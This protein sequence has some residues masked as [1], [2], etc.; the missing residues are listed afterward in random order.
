[1]RSTN[2]T[3]ELASSLRSGPDALCGSDG[4]HGVTALVLCQP[5]LCGF[6]LLTQQSVPHLVARTA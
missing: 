4:W 1:M 5:H 2:K 6:T 3:L